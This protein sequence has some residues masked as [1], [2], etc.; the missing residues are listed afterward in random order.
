MASGFWV[1]IFWLSSHEQYQK[2][3]SRANDSCRV[4]RGRILWRF[5]GVMSHDPQ[6]PESTYHLLPLTENYLGLLF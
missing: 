2:N 1:E 4:F 5:I 3:S 6:S